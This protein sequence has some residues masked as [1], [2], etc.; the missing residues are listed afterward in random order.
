[1]RFNKVSSEKI[2]YSAFLPES[3][4]RER[5]KN[6]M[7]EFL[8]GLD[9][10]ELK[11]SVFSNTV[12]F[13]K[14]RPEQLNHISYKKTLPDSVISDIS[15]FESCF[16]FG[17]LNKETYSSIKENL[18]LVYG[19]PALVQNDIRV[20]HLTE[21]KLIHQFLAI[22]QLDKMFDEDYFNFEW[23]MHVGQNFVEHRNDYM[24]DHFIHQIRDMYSM[25]ILLGN[26]GFYD[27]VFAIM[28]DRN[29]SKISQ[30]TCKKRDEFINGKQGTFS[31]ISKLQPHIFNNLLQKKQIPDYILKR[32]SSVRNYAENYFMKYVIYASAV[33]SAL[34]H[35]MGYPI[36]HFLSLRNRTSSYNPTLYMFTRNDIESFDHIS[37]ILSSSLLFTIISPEEIK[38][39]LQCDK[40]KYN[41]GAYSAIAFL[42]QFY[43]SGLIFSLPVE[44][45]CAIELAA[46]S[47]YNHTL[48]Y[49]ANDSKTTDRFY[50]PVFRQNPVSFLLRLC[51]DL[52]EWG[53]RYFEISGDSEVP[54]CSQCLTPSISSRNRLES[55]TKYACACKECNSFRFNHFN[56][57][58]LFLITTS[59]F[60]TSDI[61]TV[62][63]TDLKALRFRVDY[64]YYR[65]LLMSRINPNYA[66]YRLKELN[67]LKKLLENQKLTYHTVHEQ[68]KEHGLEFDYIYIDYFMTANPITIKLKILEKYAASFLD[69]AP[70]DISRNDIMD[71][72]NNLFNIA[73]NLKIKPSKKL[74][75]ILINGTFEFY[76]D[77]LGLVLELRSYYQSTEF[78]DN[79][80]IKAEEIYKDGRI[81]GFIDN[82]LIGNAKEKANTQNVS[83]SSHYIQI[84]SSLVFDS[85]FQ[86]AKEIVVNDVTVGPFYNQN[87]YLNQYA[88]SKG[89]NDIIYDYISAYCNSNNDFNSYNCFEKNTMENIYIGYFADLHFFEL[90]NQKNHEEFFTPN[91]SFLM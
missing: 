49:K 61:L 43:H 79:G 27:E 31:F 46:V 88:P 82:K 63:G 91:T 83:L 23:D 51:D 15:A 6:T 2:N 47:I 26:Y 86:Y 4:L 90:M 75:K 62:S 19:D 29:C 78:N 66:K 48:H 68:G 38:Q 84:M 22:P 14:D 11:Y 40:G 3:A 80:T 21:S 18:M 70:W 60:M 73:K 53:R 10:Y 65:L 41:H 81:R 64:D 17:S 16:Q 30:Y 57:R 32:C 85:A 69:K 36:C 71:L 12:F 44:K 55:K 34:F 42:M 54:I 39:S 8:E 45:Q 7:L 25:L 76:C 89:A 50:L 72:K 24:R 74:Y 52:Q 20:F 59:Y 56:S 37:S 58:K 9:P 87:K 28:S 35:D 1:M 67:D 77:L 13:Q 5:F 33:L